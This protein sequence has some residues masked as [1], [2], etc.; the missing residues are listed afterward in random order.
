MGAQMRGAA[1]YAVK[2]PASLRS[3]GTAHRGVW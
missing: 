3:L 1:R 2:N